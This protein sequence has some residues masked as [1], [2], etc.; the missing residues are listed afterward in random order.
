MKMGSSGISA[1]NTSNFFWGAETQPSPDLMDLETEMGT[2]ALA[3]EPSHIS[4]KGW[5]NI[6]ALS[7]TELLCLFLFIY[8]F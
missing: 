1:L 4:G 3:R 6:S 2:G 8:L 7:P 5:Q